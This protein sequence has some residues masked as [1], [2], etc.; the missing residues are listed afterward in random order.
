MR[1]SIVLIVLS[2]FINVVSVQAQFFYF[3][4]NRVQFENFDWRFIQ[5]EHFD[6]YYD[7]EQNYYLASFAGQS[8][9]AAY[10]QISED[11][12]HEIANRITVVIFDSH[13]DFVQTNV[14]NL[15][16]ESEGIGG[17]TELFK[18]RVVLPFMGKYGDF[19]RVLHHELVHAVI[20]DMFYGG[21]I[22][23]IIQNDIQLVIPGWFNE[24]MA[25]YSA[26]GFDT[27]T[28]NFIRDAVVN[29]YLPPI[30]YLGGYFAYRGGQSVWD[31]IVSQYGREKIGEIFQRIKTTRS[32]ELG[33]RQS[34]GLNLEELSEKWQAWLK[35]QYWPEVD[36]REDLKDISTHLTKRELAGTYNTS[37]ALSPQGDK[38]AL[39]TNERGYF[40]VVVIS[41]LT[42]KKIKTLIKGNDNID[43][44]ELNILNPNLSWSPD[45]KTLALSSKSLGKDM[46][47]L[48]NYNTGEIKRIRFPK[49]DAIESVSWSPDGKQIAFNGNI[50]AYS[51]VFVYNLDTQDFLNV[52]NDVF[53]DYEPTW[54]PDSKSI[55]FASDRGDKTRLNTYRENYNMLLNPDLDQADL[56]KLT[57]GS[58]ELVRLTNTQHAFETR[59][60]ITASNKLVYISDLNGIPN[61]Y[62]Y[63][64]K[65]GVS[66]PLTNL[67]QGVTQ[68]SISADGS[69]LAVNT[70]NGGYLDVFLIKNPFSRTEVNKPESNNWAK[71]RDTEPGYKR[72]PAVGYGYK[73]FGNDRYMS[74]LNTQAAYDLGWKGLGFKEEKPAKTKVEEVKDTTQSDLIDFRSY[75]FGEL[76]EAESKDSANTEGVKLVENYLTEDGRYQPKKYKLNFT[77]EFT[78]LNSSFNTFSG[79]Y[80]L[81][82]F[83]VS[84]VMGD[85]RFGIA[86]NLQLDLRNSSYI[87]SYEYL[88][89]RTNF[90]VNYFHYAIPFLA[91]TYDG[92]TVDLQLVRNRNYGLGVNFQYPLNTFE[93]IEYG[94]SWFNIS[95]DLSTVYNNQSSNDFQNFL[96]PTVTYTSDYTQPGFLTPSSGTRFGVSL[97]GSPAVGV[98][99]I[100]FA[101]A[102]VDF[103]TYFSMGYGYSFAIR[104][105]LA[106]SFGP[107]AQ[108]YFLG[109][110]AGWFN[111]QWEG[112]DIPID[113][114]ADLFFTQ[115]ALPMRGYN[116]NASFGNHFGLM[117]F[118]FRFPLFAA[119]LPGPL[120]ILPLYNL[121]GVM[122][123]DLGAAWGI[124]RNF[125]RFYNQNTFE[126]IYYYTESKR[127]DLRLARLKDVYLD[128]A[129]GL[130]ATPPYSDNTVYLKET[131]RQGDLLM[132]LGFGLRTILIGLPFRYDVAWPRY[133]DGL[134]K[135]IQYFSIGIDF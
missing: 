60:L 95:R 117:N 41:S 25:E 32:V 125:S 73:K 7:N 65:T 132:G 133:V 124:D 87:V 111:Y 62:E 15:P 46:L 121:T 79:V 97:T 120:P 13:N 93:R 109:G 64:F 108:T 35:K 69:R 102:M 84:D 20:N 85:H 70:F 40:D 30:D 56:Y 74:Q 45:G 129:D 63:D 42:G 43:F 106:T 11:F 47:A 81:T 71:R 116:Y 99:G 68:M 27:N 72:V 54:T 28:D 24:G 1:Y 90:S 59:P 128:P 38:I 49:L 127:L 114:L 91:Q 86:S 55:V 103:R 61:V 77:P 53:S 96:Y 31:F 104:G 112:N 76:F 3:G 98:G 83:A 105:N 51:D 92:N 131:I 10:Q 66:R 21:S 126:P 88:K 16:I 113:Q 130:I 37:P 135:P 75:Q 39:I 80:G 12:R 19:R 9:E 82:Q 34:L 110:V 94:F 52:T 33:F 5:T 26:L 58:Q 17:V 57:I 2:F 107:D 8:L 22:Q 36:K 14:V 48:V 78:Y 119:I 23:S 6:V 134:G 4:K 29:T 123:M 89:N 118:E 50:G 115:P 44:E 18:N 101:S 100:T 122:F 67:L